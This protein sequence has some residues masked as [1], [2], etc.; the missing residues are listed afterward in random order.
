MSSAM[1]LG[2][3][4]GGDPFEKVKGLISDMLATLENEAAADAS[5]KQYCDTELSEANAKHD[6]RTAESGKLSTKIAQAKAA[7]AKLKQQ[8]A[9]LQNELAAGA[10]AKAEAQQHRAAEKASY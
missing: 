10:K 7:S 5:H 3:V 1:K 6:D 2:S 4:G 8:V 9:G